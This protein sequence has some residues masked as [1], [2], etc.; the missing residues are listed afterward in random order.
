ML[1]IP[2]IHHN[3]MNKK[4]EA[5]R[6]HRWFYY[7]SPRR[8]VPRIYEPAGPS[9]IEFIAEVS[10]IPH[11]T[12]VHHPQ[13]VDQDVED[14]STKLNTLITQFRNESMQEFMT[15]KRNL[16]HEQITSIE[17]NASCNASLSAKQDEHLKEDL[18]NTG[19]HL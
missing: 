18:A 15:M 5:L 1:F 19:L 16:L 7:R 2:V 10:K 12:S 13:I 8:R 14:F 3:L 11:P 17:S 4:T 6:I 9:G